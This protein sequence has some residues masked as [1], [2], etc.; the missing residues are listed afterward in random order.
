MELCFDDARNHVI[1]VTDLERY[2]RCEKFKL[3]DGLFNN[4]F[5]IVAITRHH[6]SFFIYLW[7]PN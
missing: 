1:K 6:F 2:V 3:H 4:V 7:R 5:V